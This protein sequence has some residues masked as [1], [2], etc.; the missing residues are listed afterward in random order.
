MDKIKPSF[1]NIFIEA[2]EYYKK[3]DFKTAELYCYKILSID[4][5]NFDSISLLANIFAVNNDYVKA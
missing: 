1:K 3:K 5:N 2:V 4:K